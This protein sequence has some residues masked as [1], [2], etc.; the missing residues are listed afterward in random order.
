MHNFEYNGF[1][2]FAT[3][4]IEISQRIIQNWNHF[5]ENFHVNEPV[6]VT[7]SNKII[8]CSFHKS[9]LSTGI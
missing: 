3:L 7:H 8:E 5:L 6:D 4:M 2:N 9:G 1:T